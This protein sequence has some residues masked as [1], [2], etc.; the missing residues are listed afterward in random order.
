MMNYHQDVVGSPQPGNEARIALFLVSSATHLATLRSRHRVQYKAVCPRHYNKK[1]G[2]L[3]KVS[4]I[5]LHLLFTPSTVPSPY[6][7]YP[8]STPPFLSNHKAS[9]YISG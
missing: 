5:S 4:L 7:S 8:M 2:H 3:F 6:T 1:N 9:I